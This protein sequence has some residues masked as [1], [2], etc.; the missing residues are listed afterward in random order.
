VPVGVGQHHGAAAVQA[1]PLDQVLGLGDHLA[2]ERLPLAVLPLQVLGHLA[3]PGRVRSRQHLDHE[4]GAADTVKIV[5]ASL[6]S[7]ILDDCII[8]H[9]KE[10]AFPQLPRPF[11]TSYTY[12]FEAM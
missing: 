9:I 10:I 2:L 5:R 11:E 1:I 8:G 6:E 3:G 7:K 12:G 4:S